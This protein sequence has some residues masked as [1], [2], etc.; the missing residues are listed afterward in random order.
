MNAIRVVLGVIGALLLGGG[1]LLGLGVGGAAIV[2]AFWM[3]S[4]GVVLLIVAAV[5]VM[6]YRTGP[7]GGEIGR[8]DNRFKPTD[9]VFVDPTTERRMRV[10]TDGRTGERRYVAE[11]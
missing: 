4:S 9:E 5:E 3:I 6:R 7:G 8:P 11:G 10:Y 2:P 1:I